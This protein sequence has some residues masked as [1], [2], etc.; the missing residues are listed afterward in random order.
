MLNCRIGPHG[1]CSA[2]NLMEDTAERASEPL[3][4]RDSECCKFLAL[5]DLSPIMHV[6][7]NPRLDHLCLDAAKASNP[8]RE[9]VYQEEDFVGRIKRLLV[10]TIHQGVAL[11]LLA[12]S[13]CS[14]VYVYI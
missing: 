3:Q 9:A 14:R 2:S 13:R 11:K 1:Y 12:A 10:C 5:S 7:F 6:V 4:N 8:L